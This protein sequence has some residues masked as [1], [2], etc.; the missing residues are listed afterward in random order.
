[1]YCF[2]VLTLT[3]PAELRAENRMMLQVRLTERR[4]SIA[5][6]LTSACAIVG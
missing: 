3:D 1:M 2:A 5:E 4:S 6:F